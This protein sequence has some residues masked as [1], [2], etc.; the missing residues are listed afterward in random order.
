[1]EEIELFRAIVMIAIGIG[2]IA[3]I[4]LTIVTQLTIVSIKERKEVP[5]TFA[6]AKAKVLERRTQELVKRVL[7]EDMLEELNDLLINKSME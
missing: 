3:G 4:I 5:K 2:V 1:M 7:A 6:Q